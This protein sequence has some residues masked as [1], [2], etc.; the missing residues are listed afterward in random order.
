MSPTTATDERPAID[1]R[2][3]PDDESLRDRAVKQ[4]ERV[5][6]FELHLVA[7]FV[8][9]LALTAIWA[10]SE[11]HNA[12]GWPDRFSQSSGTPG[13]WNDWIVWPW[14]AWAFV[15]AVRAYAVFLHRPASEG[16]IQRELDRIRHAS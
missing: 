3:A 10:T 9:M 7:S 6:A 4:V 11:Y 8:G 1:L 12:G 15:M 2:G 5:R 16:E 13:T 14:I